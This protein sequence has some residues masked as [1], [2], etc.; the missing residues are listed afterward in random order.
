M[1]SNLER[2]EKAYLE[3]VGAS[4]WS[5]GCQQLPV[6]MAGPP[7]WFQSKHLSDVDYGKLL[8]L[9]PSEVKVADQPGG[10]KSP[11]TMS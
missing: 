1:L 3:E 6:T 11:V 5:E 7:L 2:T 4:R 10:S 9:A 8:P